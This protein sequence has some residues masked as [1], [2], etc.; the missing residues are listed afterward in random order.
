MIFRKNIL[1]VNKAYYPIT[2][3]VEYVVQNLAERINT[4]EFKSRVLVCRGDRGPTYVRRCNGK[5][6]IYAGSF[7]TFASLPISF[8]FFI[9]CLN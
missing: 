2:G 3:G 4:N 1:H 7:G 8:S 6:I 5:L 9:S